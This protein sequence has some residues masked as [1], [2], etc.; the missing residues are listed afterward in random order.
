MNDRIAKLIAEAHAKDIF[1][2]KVSISY[3]PFDEKLAEPMMIA[4]RL[5]EYMKAQP[6]YR[7]MISFNE[8]EYL[9]GKLNFLPSPINSV[10]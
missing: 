4:K 3:D 6:I 7:Y 9:H 5:T 2:E 1:P 8:K 10:S